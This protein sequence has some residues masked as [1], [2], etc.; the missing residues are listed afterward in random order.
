M[1]A[2]RAEL[3]H[4]D[5]LAFLLTPQQTHNLGIAFLE[6]LLKAVS[7]AHGARFG[8]TVDN[9]VQLNLTRTT[10][11]RE[12]QH[13]DILILDD[14]GKWVVVIENKI[15]ADEGSEQLEEYYEIVKRYYPNRTIIAIYL[16]PDGRSPRK[17]NS[18][19]LP[20]DYGVVADALERVWVT[21]ERAQDVDPDARVAVTHYISMLRRYVVSDSDIAQLCRKIY[22]EHRRAVDLIYQ[23]RPMPH[24]S[25]RDALK[26]MVQED[27]R[28]KLEVDRAIRYMKVAVKKWEKFPVLQI[29]DH[30]ALVL[31][32]GFSDSHIQLSLQIGPFAPKATSTVQQQLL[33]MATTHR[34][35][36]QPPQETG[37]PQYTA[38]Y[39][40]SLLERSPLPLT[41]EEIDEVRRKWLDFLDGDFQAINA[42]VEGQGWLR[43]GVG[44]GSDSRE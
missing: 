33:D 13:I 3:R 11:R 35:P 44:D 36:F 30:C 25:I 28:F 23:H 26:S 20:L 4:S 2:V 12:W 10:V 24:L 7:V 19:F 42:V 9:L 41:V 43:Q 31:V 27:P 1:G 37:S 38:I 15:D 8:A 34:P 40:A 18:P 22:E 29:S 5:F 14:D 17:P 21:N 16:T 6:G 32:F 39:T